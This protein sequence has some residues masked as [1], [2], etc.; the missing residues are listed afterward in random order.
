MFPLGPERTGRFLDYFFAPDVDQAWVDELVAFD[1][2]VGLEDRALVECVQR[3]IRSGVL[4]EGRLLSESEQLV[5]HFQ[6]L[7]RQALERGPA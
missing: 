3:G 1:T 4:S 6:T 2:Q 7:T 5:V